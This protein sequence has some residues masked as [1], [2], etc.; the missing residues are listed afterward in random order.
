M[1]ITK[2]LGIVA[3]AAL[4]CA[5]TE[6]PQTASTRKADAEPW[7]GPPDAFMAQGWKVGDKASWEQQMRQRAQSQNEY[8]RA[9]A[10][11]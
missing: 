10:Q 7:Q 11:P 2:S 6:K 5:C 8:S 9:A 3:L 4:L 1:T